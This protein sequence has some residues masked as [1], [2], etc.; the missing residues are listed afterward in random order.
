MLKPYPKY[1]ESGVQWIGKIPEKWEVKKIKHLVYNLDGKRI[2]ISAEFREEGETPYYGATG[3]LEYVKGHIFNET[4]LLVGEDGAPFFEPDKNVAFVIEGKTWVNNH[5]HVLRV[6][7]PNNEKWLCAFM[8]SNDYRQYIKGSTRDKLNQDDLNNIIVAVPSHKEEEIIA[9]FIDNRSLEIDSIIQKDQHLIDLLK[10]KRIALINHIVT[11]GLD[12][13]A[14][15]KKI[16]HE[17]ISEIPESWSVMDLKHVVSTKI[18]DGPHETPELLDEGIP[19][20]SAEAIKKDKI[21]FSKMRGFISQENHKI[22]CLK[23]KPKKEDVFLIKSG[24]TTGNVAIVETE[25]EFSIWSPLALIRSNKEKLK[26]KLLYY[27]LL[28]DYFKKII[29]LSWS[30]GTQQNIG[31]GVIENITIVVPDIN[32]QDLI[33]DHLDRETSKIDKTIALIEKKIDLLEE[34]KKSLIHHVV[35]GKV[36]VRGIE[37]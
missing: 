12:P 27:I 15:L 33:M 37:A 21:D 32:E 22:Y 23:S 11:K 28:S 1:K 31:M 5:A 4:L 34:F 24:A 10:E 17:L 9:S 26:P 2:P 16:T 35:T 18:T 3:I 36:D 13:K 29:E 19:F 25:E 20:I 6:N 30:Y 7:K 8:N 14:K